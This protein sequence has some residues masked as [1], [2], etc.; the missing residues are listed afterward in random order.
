[1]TKGSFCQVIGKDSKKCLSSLIKTNF[2]FMESDG[3]I[4]I[5]PA[6]QYHSDWVLGALLLKEQGKKNEIEAKQMEKYKIIKATTMDARNGIREID[7]EIE[8]L[9]KELSM[10]RYD[11]CRGCGHDLT[12]GVKASCNICKN[13]SNFKTLLIVASTYNTFRHAVHLHQKCS[14]QLKARFGEEVGI[15]LEQRL[16]QTTL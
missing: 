8:L 3:S 11:E 1:M 7:K 2:V 5:K 9:R 12:C 10:I 14:R 16:L 4:V 6:C 13:T 15:T